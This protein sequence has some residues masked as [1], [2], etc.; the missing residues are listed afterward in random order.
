MQGNVS[1][2]L[3]PLY[4]CTRFPPLLYP[5]TS[6]QRHVSFSL[7]STLV[8]TNRETFPPPFPLPLYP[9]TETRFLLSSLYPCTHVQ[10]HVSSSL[11]STLV[12]IYRE[13]FRPSLS[14]AFYQCTGKRFLLLSLYRRGE[15]HFY[16]RQA[17]SQPVFS[18]KPKGPFCLSYTFIFRNERNWMKKSSRVSE[19]LV[20][21]GLP[22]LQLATRLNVEGNGPSLFTNMNL[23][24]YWQSS[25]LYNVVFFAVLYF[26]YIRRENRIKARWTLYMESIIIR[27]LGCFS[28]FIF[29]NFVGQNINK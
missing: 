29:N 21:P 7:P 4:Q 1:S 19:K 15:K 23:Y 3:L 11:P 12:P 27:E 24:C 10:R 6:V 25:R 16:K 20:S 14:L 5:C 17:C 8:P 18:G 9:C 28:Y 13:K 2:S 26:I 22:G